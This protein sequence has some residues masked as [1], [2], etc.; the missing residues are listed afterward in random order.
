MRVIQS[1]INSDLS[2]IS[3]KLESLKIGED[4]LFDIY[5]KRDN[6]YYIIVESGV[7]ITQELYDKLKKQTK[8]FVKKEDAVKLQ[9]S[10]E[11]L[12]HYLMYSKG[13]V[14]KSLD[15]LYTINNKIFETY[16]ESKENKIDLRCVNSLINSI[17]YL[18]SQDR[19]YLKK[20]LPHFLNQHELSSHSLH[21]AIYS[22]KIGFV[23]NFTI[24]KLL[25]LGTAALLH[26]IG[27]KKIDDQII[28]KN[29]KLTLEELE[30]I[31]QHALYSF[32]IAKDNSIHDSDILDGILH[33]H[34]NY[35]GSGYPA[36]LKGKDITDF[37]AI[38]GIAD[39]FDALT[40]IRANRE[41]YNSFQALKIM[42]QDKEMAD[43]FNSR[44]LQLFLKSL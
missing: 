13:D 35:N 15:F 16:L 42:M 7:I 22:L 2:H 4:L 25:K 21:V 36:H 8:L 20:M 19:G 12:K 41:A 39:V 14:V 24:E 26:D 23:S 27:L 33:H 40:N 34:E 10:C 44:F 17:I 18:I 43:R 32:E 3:L 9:L 1:K 29:D 28:Q 31:Q 37:A 30:S 38:I 6:D 5:I 11:S